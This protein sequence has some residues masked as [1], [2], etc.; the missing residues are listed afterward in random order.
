MLSVS[1]VL[2][3]RNRPAHIAPCVQAILANPDLLELIVVDQSEGTASQEALAPIRDPRLRYVRSDTRGVT[4]SR[5][6]GIEM[7]KG[8]VIACTDDDCRVPADWA[9]RLAHLFA[10]D[11]DAAVVCGR[12][13]IPDEIQKKGY[14]VGFEPEVRD[15]QGRIPPPD[16]DWGITANLAIRRSVIESVGAFDAMLGAGAPLKSGGEPDFLFR[17][18][19][20][21]L[22]VV[23]AS[24]V[25]VIHLGFRV[26]GEETRR[27]IYA[28]GS[29]LSAALLKHVRLGDLQGMLLYLRWVAWFGRTISSNLLRG[30][31]PGGA[32]ALGFLSGHWDSIRYRI[33]RKRRLY[34]PRPG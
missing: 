30:R 1:A 27:L 8:D 20:A 2:P 29:G 32:F 31:R 21:G 24:E 33:D 15:W 22:K 26:P 34:V 3:T 4:A 18:L 9:A 25:E 12:V 13:T 23:N 6:V 28:Y 14:A 19:R 10:A 17:V 16:H 11:R 5:N 7:S